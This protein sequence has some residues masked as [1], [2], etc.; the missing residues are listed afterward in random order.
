[1]YQPHK[2][3]IQGHSST[4]RFNA[5]CWGRQSGKTTYGLNKTADRAWCEVDSVFKS[6][7]SGGTNFSDHTY[8]YILQTYDAAQVA[9]K[10]LYAIYRQCPSAF[11][12]KPN[13]SDLLMRFRNGNEI[14]FKSGRNYEDLRIETLK[15]CVIDEYRQQYKDLFPV[16]IRPMLGRKNGWCDLLST[17]NGFEH[18]YDIWNT[19]MG[20]PEW[21]HFKNPSTIAPWW[22]PIEIASARKTMS[23]AEFEQE[24][25]AEF[26]NIHVGK[27]YSCEGTWNQRSFSPFGLRDEVVSR[28]LPITVGLDFNVGNMSWHL[29]QFRGASSF[30]FD[31]IHVENTN[32]MECAEELGRRLLALKAN[33]SLT[34]SNPQVILCG[35]ATGNSRH[36][37]A[38]ESDYAII[39]GKLDSLGIKWTNATP[40]ANPPVTERVNT[41]N[42]RLKSADGTVNFFYDPIKCP[43]LKKDFDRVSWKD[44]SSILDQVTDKSLTHASDSIGYAVHR[45][46]PIELYGT[47]K[48]TIVKSKF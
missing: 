31:E 38:T 6:Y 18:F 27:V 17:P 40:K 25:L 19:T 15:G 42:A 3:Q 34:G 2:G 46:A 36:S 12:K 1:M 8:W 43:R 30:W 37:S 28:Y 35:D 24:Y 7:S 23:T 21:G 13:E 16:V 22:T 5:L 29:G 9:F 39:C 11:D 33:G 32:T 41:V 26:R 44:G 4:K 14:G 10:R 45:F 48:L 47:G 20:D